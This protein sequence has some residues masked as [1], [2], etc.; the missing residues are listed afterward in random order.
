VAAQPEAE[1]HSSGDLVDVL[2]ARPSRANEALF[3]VAFVEGDGGGDMDGLN[4][5]INLAAKA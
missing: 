3:E 1:F 5:R 2:S 4:H